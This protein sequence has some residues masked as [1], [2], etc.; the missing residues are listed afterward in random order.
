MQAAAIHVLP[1]AWTGPIPRA[2]VRDLLV[3][4]LLTEAPPSVQSR[5]ELA[6]GP[7]L[8]HRLVEA[9]LGSRRSQLR[10]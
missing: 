8:A 4:I 1:V 5:L 3:A 6:L 10:R 7:D 9:L 2:L